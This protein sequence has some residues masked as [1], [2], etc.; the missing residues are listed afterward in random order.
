MTGRENEGSPMKKTKGPR[1]WSAIEL[2]K[3]GV[4]ILDGS[5]GGL[6]CDKCRSTW[7]TNLP[8]RRTRLRG[9]WKCPKG[10]NT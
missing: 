1:Y 5:G 7:W 9:Y 6:A 4:S 3:V 8:S 10:C 2:K